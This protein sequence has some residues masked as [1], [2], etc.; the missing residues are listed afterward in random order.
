ML[1]NEDVKK[2]AFAY[3]TILA[4]YLFL[5]MKHGTNTIFFVQYSKKHELKH[6]PPLPPKKKAFAHSYAVPG[7]DLGLV[8]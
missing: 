6:L 4:S 8:S 7:I 1:T 2:L 5:F 3:G